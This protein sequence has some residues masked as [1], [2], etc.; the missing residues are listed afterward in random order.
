VTLLPIAADGR[1]AGWEHLSDKRNP[2]GRVLLNA[3]EEYGKDNKAAAR[4]DPEKSRGETPDEA[5]DNAIKQ[6]MG[7][8]LL[9]PSAEANEPTTPRQGNRQ[10][11]FVTWHLIDVS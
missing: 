9:A 10:R 6:T 8:Q 5:D 4:T 11:F 7:L 1:K 3:E 2:L